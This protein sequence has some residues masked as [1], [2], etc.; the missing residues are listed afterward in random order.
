MKIWTYGSSPPSGSR[1]VW[2]PVKNVNGDNRL[3]NIWNFFGAIQMISYRDW[4]PW[5]K[6][7]YITMTRRKTN[8]QCSGG[9]AGYT[10]P[11]IPSA[12]S[13]E[14]ISPVFFGVKT[15]SSSLIIFQRANVSTRSITHLCW[16]NWRTFWRENPAVNSR[17]V[18]CSCTKIP[19]LTGHLKPRKNWPPWWS[20]ILTTHPTLR[21]RPRRTTTSYLFWQKHKNV[22]NFSFD[23]L[24]NVAEKASLDGKYPNF[25]FFWWLAKVTATG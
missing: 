17:K 8:N 6:P 21:I 22:Q 24:V 3:S 19:R 12:N 20:S 23:A 1:N 14:N 9:I 5:T 15:A 16:C 7:G 2:T 10:T 13:A 4:W 11:K 25:F 18:S